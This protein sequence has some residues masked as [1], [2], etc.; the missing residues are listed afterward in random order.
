MDVVQAEP[1]PPL[2]YRVLRR[3]YSGGQ[4]LAFDVLV[5]AVLTTARATLMPHLTPRV[6]GQVWHTATWAAWIAASVAVLFRRRAPAATLAAVVPLV[7]FDLGVRAN[8]GAGPFYLVMALYS[9]SV[10]SSRRRALTATVMVAAADVLATVV[11]GGDQAVMGTIGGVA[12]I[13]VGWL[14]SENTRAARVFAEQNAEREVERATAADRARTQLVARAVTEERTQIARELH[15]VV[16]HAMSVIAVRAGVARMVIDAQPEQARDA[17][18]II[19]TTTR[20]SLQEMRLLVGVLRG[21]EDQ[22]A[23]LTPAPG[24]SNLPELVG[25]VEL[26]GVTV[27]VRV[28]GD[29]RDLPTALDL[30]AYRIIQEALTN[31]VRHAGPTSAHVLLAY[32][33]DELRIEVRDEGAPQ[34]RTRESAVNDY[35]GGHGLIG[36]RERAALFDG[37]VT[38]GPSRGGFEVITSLRTSHFRGDGATTDETANSSRRR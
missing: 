3:R 8:G 22:S 36:I 34:D 10:M 9:Y 4:L 29:R 33:S 15:D 5:V 17:L 13:S 1:E 23:S 31:V 7:V 6:D 37:C 2:A 18:G 14:A 27:D 20:R 11:G 32:R 21:A 24:L 16:A 25:G 12:I 19:E 38:A 35:G 26:A 28:E 30:C